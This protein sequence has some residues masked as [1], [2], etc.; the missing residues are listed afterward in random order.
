MS[1]GT[2]KRTESHRG[3]QQ[4]DNQGLLD[5]FTSDGKLSGFRMWEK[6][7]LVSVLNRWHWSS[8][9]RAWEQTGRQV[10]RLIRG[11]WVQVVSECCMRCLDPRYV[12]KVLLLGFV[13]NVD[14]GLSIWLNDDA[15]FLDK[16]NVQDADTYSRES[17]HYIYEPGVR[18]QVR[19]EGIKLGVQL[20]GGFKSWDSMR[21]LR[22]WV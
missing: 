4:P 20:V 17:G 1:K 12:L 7:G 3:G 15:I 22:E 18:R 6:N 14:F 5:L 10:K 21:S 9:Y 13:D 2:S 8:L 16:E 19:A 11:T